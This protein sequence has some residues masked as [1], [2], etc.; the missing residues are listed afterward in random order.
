[1]G[2][3]SILG[4]LPLQIRHKLSS[5]ANQWSVNDVIWVCVALCSACLFSGCHQRPCCC[6]SLLIRV[7]VDLPVYLALLELREERWVRWVRPSSLANSVTHVKIK[8]GWEHKRMSAAH[9]GRTSIKAPGHKCDWVMWQN[10]YSCEKSRL[11]SPPGGLLTP[12]FISIKG[13]PW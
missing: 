5:Q 1:M 11:M 12:L 8:G 3:I 13:P 2:G 7:S 6:C 4:E 10:G 9:C